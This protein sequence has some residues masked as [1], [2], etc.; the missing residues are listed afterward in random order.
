MPTCDHPFQNRSA[1]IN[2]FLAGKKCGRD[3]GVI[4]GADFSNLVGR[5]RTDENK[6]ERVDVGWTFLE[7]T[8]CKQT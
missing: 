2:K 3:A 7:H 5:K 8:Y 1:K 4:F 6:Q